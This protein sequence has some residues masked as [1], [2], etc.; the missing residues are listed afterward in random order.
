MSP[1]SIAS[2]RFMGMMM[3]DGNSI[4]QS[5]FL[6]APSQPP[7]VP[8]C[9]CVHMRA[10]TPAHGPTPPADMAIAI[11]QYIDKLFQHVR[12]RK[13][14]VMCVDGVAPRA[15]MNQQEPFLCDYPLDGLM[16]LHP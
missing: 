16:S 1:E 12:P 13:H 6:H 3:V 5:G 9:T 10:R 14:F 15:K 8:A 11:F 4:Y 2:P 7:C